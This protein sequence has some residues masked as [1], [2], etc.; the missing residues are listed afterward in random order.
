MLGSGTS[1]VGTGFVLITG[2]SGES[3]F[4]PKR[5]PKTPPATA[6]APMIGGMK[7]PG[8]LELGFGT[9]P[10]RKGPD[11]SGDA[12]AGLD[13]AASTSGLLSSKG[14]GVSRNTWVGSFGEVGA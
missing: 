1:A 11:C 14:I 12:L 8:R 5:G 13:R 2:G 3:E 7:R 9:K 6:P 4:P 10:K